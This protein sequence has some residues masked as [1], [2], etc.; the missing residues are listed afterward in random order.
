MI[1]ELRDRI[2]ES[3]RRTLARQALVS[4]VDLPVYLA[5]AAIDALGLTV[6]ERGAQ[7]PTPVRRFGRTEWDNRE[8]TLYRVVGQ[9]EGL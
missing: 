3:Q 5:Q 7:E 4:D 9:W 6:E 2:A 8:V 1:D